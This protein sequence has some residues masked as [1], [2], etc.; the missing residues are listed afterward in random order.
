[1]DR[2]LIYTSDIPKL[3]NMTGK[4]TLFIDNAH[5]PI[6][7]SSSDII[8][9]TKCLFDAPEATRIVAPCQET[10]AEVIAAP[11]CVTMNNV[12]FHGKKLPK[13]ESFIGNLEEPTYLPVCKRFMID[14]FKQFEV[15]NCEHLCVTRASPPFVVPD[16]VQTIQ[17]T[18]KT[19]L[20]LSVYNDFTWTTMMW[21]GTLFATGVRKQQKASTHAKIVKPRFAPI[22]YPINIWFEIVGNEFKDDYPGVAKNLNSKNLPYAVKIRDRDVEHHAMPVA[23]IKYKAEYG[24][25]YIKI[26]TYDA[27]NLDYYLI[28][29]RW[30]PDVY[31]RC[32]SD[33][34]L[35]ETVDTIRHDAPE[36][37]I[38]ELQ[39]SMGSVSIVVVDGPTNKAEQSDD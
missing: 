21:E 28:K 7:T 23:Y 12:R 16:T 24:R 18:N 10:P 31:L 2:T 39:Y 17:C 29:Y 4:V 14:H 9:H 15:P 11:N 26:V 13:C 25:H 38:N 1:M 19:A 5:S 35:Q 8:S 20:G 37:R 22:K 34:D 33:E 6:T 30:G 27:A 3:E 36:R 32:D